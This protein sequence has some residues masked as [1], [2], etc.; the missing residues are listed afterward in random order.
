MALG[1]PFERV[2]DQILVRW[3]PVDGLAVVDPAIGDTYKQDGS[4]LKCW[5]CLMPFIPG[6]KL[7]EALTTANNKPVL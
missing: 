2:I 7:P 3:T 4:D 1:V 6:G 5:E